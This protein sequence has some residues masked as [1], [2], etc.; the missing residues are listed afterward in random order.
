[1]NDYERQTRLIASVEMSGLTYDLLEWLSRGLDDHAFDSFS[2]NAAALP[3]NMKSSEM[4]YV[5]RNAS[6]PSVEM[7]NRPDSQFS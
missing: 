2:G 6:A 7:R 4:L 5:S 3:Q 1:M